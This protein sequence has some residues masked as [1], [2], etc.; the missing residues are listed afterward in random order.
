[1]WSRIIPAVGPSPKV[2]VL[3]WAHYSVSFWMGP[4]TYATLTGA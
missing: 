3:G 1:M 4:G 2:L